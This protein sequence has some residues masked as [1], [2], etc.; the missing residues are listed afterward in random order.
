MV[1]N[2][3]V[4]FE[5]E[6]GGGNNIFIDDIYVNDIK[7]GIE[8]VMQNTQFK[9][10]PNPA[11]DFLQLIFSTEIPNKVELIDIHGKIIY[12]FIPTNEKTITVPINYLASGMYFI[13]TISSS[14][15]YYGR[16]IKK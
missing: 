14:S 8:D 12:S 15:N 13:H 10:I 2:F 5:F 6:S 11:E 7:M 3:R 4:K 9:I 16:F 1:S